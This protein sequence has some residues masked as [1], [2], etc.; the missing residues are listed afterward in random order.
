M[1][2][3]PTAAVPLSTLLIHT[4]DRRADTQRDRE[5]WGHRDVG[6]THIHTYTQASHTYTQTY[7]S[8]HTHHCC[9]QR[10]GYGDIRVFI[11]T[12]VSASGSV[13]GAVG[14][15]CGHRHGWCCIAVFPPPPPLFKIALQDTSSTRL[16]YRSRLLCRSSDQVLPVSCPKDT[17][18]RKEEMMRFKRTRMRWIKAARGH[19]RW[20]IA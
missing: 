13:S 3:S 11:N 6:M 16:L 12:Y 1:A 9:L 8:L 17:G 15:V 7:P 5:R 10:H 2:L 18:P 14:M 4:T 20:R 19:G